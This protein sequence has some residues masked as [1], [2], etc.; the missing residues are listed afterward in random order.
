MELRKAQ[1]KQAKLRI[2]LSWPSGSGKTYSALLLARWMATSWDKVAIIDTENGSGELYSHLGNYNAITLDNFSPVTYVLAIKACEDAGME[3]I[4]IDSITHEWKYILEKVDELSKWA[5]NSFT[6][7]WTA[8]PFHDKF[9]QAILQSKCH[10]ITTVRSKQDYD[11]V[12][13]IST[14]KTTIQKLWMKHE[15]REGFEY[16]LTVSLDINTDHLAKTSKDRTGLFADDLGWFKITEEVGKKIK[17]WN[18]EGKIEEP[19]PK[20]STTNSTP[21]ND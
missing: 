20:I 9:V 3:V 13:D 14:G 16:E 11:M 2:G 7:W 17:A 1:R 5:K 6:A 18:Q 21:S 10:V 19:I 8:T 15:S 4:I 12:K